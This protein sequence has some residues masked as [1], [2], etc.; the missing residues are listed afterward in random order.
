MQGVTRYASFGIFD[1]LSWRHPA[2]DYRVFDR[3][4][5]ELSPIGANAVQLLQWGASTTDTD[6]DGLQDWWEVM[7]GT[8]PTVWDTDGDGVRDG[9]DNFPLDPTRSAWGPNAYDHTPP[10]LTLTAPAGAVLNP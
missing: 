1:N 9:D 4:T 5:G 10:A 7:I 2:L 8:I 3:T 6:G